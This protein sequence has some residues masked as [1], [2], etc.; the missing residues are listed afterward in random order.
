M[1][2]PHSSPLGEAHLRRVLNSYVRYY[3]ES[4]IHRSLSKVTPFPARL[5]ASGSSHRNLSSAVFIT[6]IAESDFRYR[7]VERERPCRPSWTSSRRLPQGA[8]ICSTRTYIGRQTQKLAAQETT[9]AA[10]S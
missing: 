10:V 6:N 3:N 7:Q 2:R 4:R 8:M 1:C 5:S 9:W